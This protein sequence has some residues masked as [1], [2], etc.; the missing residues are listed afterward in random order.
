MECRKIHETKKIDENQ[1]FFSLNFDAFSTLLIL[2]IF[3][4]KHILDAF[5]R[6][7]NCRYEAWIALNI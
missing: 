4:L 3:I 2:I 6:R 5:K 1:I 7:L